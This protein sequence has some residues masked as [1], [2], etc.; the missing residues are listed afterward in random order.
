VHNLSSFF[1]FQNS[2]E[3]KQLTLKQEHA[4]KM[5]HYTQHQVMVKGDATADFREE[6]EIAPF[7]D[8]A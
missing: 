8:C 5:S 2:E 3:E 4:C 6:K 1:S 7:G